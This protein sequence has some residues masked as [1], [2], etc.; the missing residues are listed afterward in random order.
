MPTHF[1]RYAELALPQLL[2]DNWRELSFDLASGHNV[3]QNSVVPESG[4]GYV[5]KDAKSIGSATHNRFIYW[6]TVNDVLELIEISS[7][8]NLDDNQIRIRFVN[9]PIVNSINVIEFSENIAIVLVTMTS[10]H[11]ILLPHPRTIGTS[12]FVNLT[13][14]VL[15]D[16]AN[17][18]L[19]ENHSSS[20]QPI[21]ATSWF[22]KSMLRCA[23]SFPDSSILI[24][25]FG[26]QAHQISTSE[27]KQ[28]GIIGRLW[29]KMP[30]L[31]A[32]GPDEC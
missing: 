18:Y 26:H 16:P 3:L 17:Y 4:S 15:F 28:T 27:I 14:D 2:N 22:A 29:S 9:S 1:N 30:N 6:R 12:V 20:M 21:C 5:Y 25:Q 10:V 7:E 32:K 31:W 24:V 8:T 23:L 13:S 19:L 11:R